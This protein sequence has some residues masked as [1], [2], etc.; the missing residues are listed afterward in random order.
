MMLCSDSGRDG[1]RGGGW[2]EI[3]AGV[4]NLTKKRILTGIEPIG[5]II[6]SIIILQLVLI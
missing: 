1:G 5:F 2:L 3:V 6:F 4:K